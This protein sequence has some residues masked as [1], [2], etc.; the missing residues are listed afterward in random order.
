MA[1][2]KKVDL[3]QMLMIPVCLEDQIQTD[4][5]EHAIHYLIEE[6]LDISEFDQ[7]YNND[8]TGSKAYSPAMLL[9]II[10][11]GYSRGLISSRK[12]EQA[13]QENVLFMAMTGGQKPDHST[14]AAFISTV[15]YELIS[16]LFAQVLLIC[17]QEDLLGGTHFSLDGLKLPA[18]ASKEWTGKE[19]ELKKKKSKLDKKLRDTIAEHRNVDKNESLRDTQRRQRRLER[20]KKSSDRIKRFLKKNT[21]RK[22][23]RGQEV[24]TNI[25]D[26]E[27][28]YMKTS[29][30]MVQGY[31]AQALVDSENQ[32]ITC[33]TVSNDPQDHR[34]LEKVMDE[35]VETAEKAELGKDYY[36]NK[37]VSADSS[38]HSNHNLKVS[39]KYKLDSYIPDPQFRKRDVRFKNRGHHKPKSDR[40]KK[41][42]FKYHPEKD[43]Y[44]CPM[45]R[46]LAHKAT[47]YRVEGIIY[48]EYYTQPGACD[49]CPLKERCIRRKNAKRKTL[50]VAIGAHVDN[51]C[52]KMRQ[53]IDTP[54]GRSIYQRR[55]AIVEPVYANI[56]EHKGM[57]RFTLRG[58]RKTGIQWKLYCLVHNIEKLARLKKPG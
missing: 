37:I 25:T 3:K 53:K 16:S 36:A 46:N 56:R 45:G 17:D 10:L 52:E 29:H 23:Y 7:H 55:L 34:N 21:P 57:R 50:S 32:I 35:A 8:Q 13:C 44:T 18:N 15:D 28:T 19:L 54:R 2:Y 4:T 33:A 49:G 40:L 27:S 6:C 39:E 24:R 41:E 42:D 14:I 20:L 1:R 12:I 9:K 51:R 38:Y 43:H 26:P 58:M 31:N 5:L 47:S 48:K 30:G 22:G 11:L